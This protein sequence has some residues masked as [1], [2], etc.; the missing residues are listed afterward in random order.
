MGRKGLGKLAGF[1]VAKV[2]E[3]TTRREGETHATKIQLDYDELVKKQNVHEIDVPEDFLADG[4]GFAESGTKITLSRLLYDPLKSRSRTIEQE[5]A[6]YFALIDE[7]EFSIRLNG[8]TVRPA[9]RT[10]VYA[11]PQPNDLA[12]DQFV[13]KKLPREGGG[14]ITFQYRIRF[15]GKN[16]ALAAEQRGV[17]VYAHKRLA[18]APSLLAADTNMH[19]FRMTD[20]LDGVVHADF[21]DEE[22]ADYISTDRE[23]LRWESPLLSGL[24]EFL[25]EEITEACKQYAKKREEDAPKIVQ[26][27]PFTC[28][29]VDNHD[30]SKKDRK[31][32]F[33]FAEI[34]E[35]TYKRGIDDPAYKST[36]PPLLNGIGH[37]NILTAIT[38]LAEQPQPELDR[39][40]HEIVRL[41]RDE[42]D[43]FIGCVKGR[44]K[45]IEAL[46]KIIE[47]PDFKTKRNEKR[48]QELMEECPWLVD[49]TYTQFLLVADVSLG[50]LFKRL[51]QELQI[52]AYAATKA[53]AKEPD[54]VFL[55]GNLSLQ[56][57]VIVELKASNVTL[58]AENLGQLE[59]YMQRTEEWL[60]AQNMGGFKVLGHLIGTKASPKSQAKGAVMLR[61]RIDKAGPDTSWRV[62]DYLE[63]LTDT[64]AAHEELMTI[65]RNLKSQSDDEDT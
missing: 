35:K 61:R 32:A 57:I 30:F 41:T 64:N 63:V 38:A 13:E 19:G 2:M 9:P 23:S 55:I 43:Q 14:E 40:V 45:G 3:V 65:H 34:L 49:P 52:G 51:A 25:G 27:D 48:I 60:E 11:W 31:L 29:E 12:V 37:G 6:D 33:R 7:S 42:F 44:L 53:D 22:Q 47:H 46:R 8:R 62:R 58:E 1:G 50:T 21:I 26:N 24:Y 59:Y 54:L 5:I 10:L 15:T 17:R 20:Y 16:E 28:G 39:V 56:R 4:G 18:A 36:L